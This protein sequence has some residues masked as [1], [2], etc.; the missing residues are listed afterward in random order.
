VISKQQ[1]IS[2]HKK[3]SN[4]LRASQ[5]LAAESSSDSGEDSAEGFVGEEAYDV[6]RSV[7]PFHEVFHPQEEIDKP[8]YNLNPW[9]K[10]E[11]KRFIQLLVNAPTRGVYSDIIKTMKVVLTPEVK[12]SLTNGLR[13][14]CTGVPSTEATFFV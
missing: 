3:G 12:S 6:A 1:Q 9:I 14:R 2:S 10:K 4:D 8:K 7:M 13:A 5:S 11:M